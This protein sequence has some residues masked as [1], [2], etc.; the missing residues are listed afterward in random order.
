MWTRWWS[1]CRRGSISNWPCRRCRQASTCSWRS[2]PSSAWRTTGGCGRREI[3]PAA[4]S[5]SAR[6]ITTSRWPSACGGC[7]ARGSWATSCSPSSRR[8]SSGSRP[9]T[10]GATT[11]AW[12]GV[13]PSS[14]RAST[15]CTS[16]TAWGRPSPPRSGSRR[17]LRSGGRTDARR[18]CWPRFGTR[19]GRPGRCST[20][21]RCPPCC[22]GSACRSCTGG[23]AS[24]RS[25]PTGASCWFGAA[26]SRGSCSPG[27][28]TYAA[29]R[30]C[31]A[32]SRAPFDPAG[33]RR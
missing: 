23:T 24:S 14:R 19:T 29:T 22:A 7:W 1:R 31:I 30:R 8:W 17:R 5:W 2:P 4:W 32:T 15:G 12:R 21:A 3:A 9:P 16:P 20:R 27:F 11:R 6:T 28:G 13:T 18:A 10:T 25:S 33:R 26:A